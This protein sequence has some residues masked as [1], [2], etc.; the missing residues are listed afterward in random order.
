MTIWRT[1]QAHPDDASPRDHRR[2]AAVLLGGLL[3]LAVAPL[4]ILPMAALWLVW[5]VVRWGQREATRLSG[6]PAE[7]PQWGKPW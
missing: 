7:R 6:M 3:V 1:L 5:A 2:A 4:A